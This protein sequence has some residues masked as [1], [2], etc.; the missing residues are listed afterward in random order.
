MHIGVLALQGAF[1]EHI[2]ALEAIDARATA[3]RLPE[4]LADLHFGDVYMWV[5]K[6]VEASKAPTP[7]QTGSEN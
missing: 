1:R 7:P 4:Q 2:Y 3:V 6:G 5:R